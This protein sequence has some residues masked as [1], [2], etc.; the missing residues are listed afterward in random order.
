MTFLVLT[1]CRRLTLPNHRVNSRQTLAESTLDGSDFDAFML[2]APEAR[3]VRRPARFEHLRPIT[4]G[5]EAVNIPIPNWKAST[6]VG[7]KV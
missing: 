4:S 2:D 7:V 6:D 3:S 5:G 1:S